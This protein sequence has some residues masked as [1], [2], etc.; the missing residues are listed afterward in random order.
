MMDSKQPNLDRRFRERYNT[1]L[2]LRNRGKFDSQK[3]DL[4]DDRSIKS[5]FLFK[6]DSKSARSRYKPDFDLNF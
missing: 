6:N 2:F 5:Q 4:I 3:M 1:N